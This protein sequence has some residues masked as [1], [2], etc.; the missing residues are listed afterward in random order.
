MDNSL[1]EDSASFHEGF[2]IGSRQYLERYG[3]L[4]I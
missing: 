3:L 4:K 2:S 1:L